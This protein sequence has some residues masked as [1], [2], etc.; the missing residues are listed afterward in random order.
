MN[1]VIAHMAP[2]IYRYGWWA[3]A[4]AILP[5]GFGIPLPGESTLIAACLV[6]AKDRISLFPIIAAA[7][8]AAALGNTIGYGLG[9]YGGRP[10]VLRYGRFLLITDAG[11]GR[12][13]KF[14]LRYGGVIILVSRFLDVFRQLNGVVAGLTSMPFL[15][16]QIYNIL[17]AALW[18]GC[19]A[20]LAFGFSYGIEDMHLTFTKIR[21]VLLAVLF[22]A[23][24]AALIYRLRARSTGKG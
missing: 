1:G 17:G 23:S 8:T 15:K 2:Y 3:V 6:A 19:C 7:F 11:L 9:F 18:V 20:G 21:Y 12:T 24:I 14:F 13:E 5:E 4:A 16:F 22:I 10:L